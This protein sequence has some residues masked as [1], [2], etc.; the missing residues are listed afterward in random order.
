MASDTTGARSASLGQAAIRERNYGTALQLLRRAYRAD[1]SPENAR[2]LAT[3]Y[4]EAGYLQLAA[5]YRELA[6]ER[7]ETPKA[8]PFQASTPGELKQLPPQPPTH[9]TVPLPQPVPPSS[10][11]PSSRDQPIGVSKPLAPKSL[12]RQ[13]PLQPLAPEAASSGEHSAQKANYLPVQHA[14][15]LQNPQQGSPFLRRLHQLH[16][17]FKDQP[18]A[19]LALQLAEAY[20]EQKNFKEAQRYYREVLDLDHS[21]LLRPMVLERLE[22][23]QRLQGG[24]LGDPSA[25]SLLKLAEKLEQEGETARAE[26]VY[27]QILKMN[28]TLDIHAKARKGLNRLYPNGKP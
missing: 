23:L 11:S 9:K 24:S 18:T 17:Q 28:T 3:A 4:E 16:R 10:P 1:P 25:Q 26:Q 21:W 27:R 2:W 14:P 6:Q 15:D 7:K 5:L 20:D 12:S 8:I 19:E 13:V 22:E